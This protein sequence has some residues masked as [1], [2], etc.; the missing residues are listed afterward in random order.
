MLPNDNTTTVRM[1]REDDTAE[2]ANGLL[3]CWEECGA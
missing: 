2:A 1:L 3:G